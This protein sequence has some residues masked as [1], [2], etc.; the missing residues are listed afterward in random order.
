V[1][2]IAIYAKLETFFPPHHSRHNLLVNRLLGMQEFQLPYMYTLAA[3]A[4]IK[5]IL[6]MPKFSPKKTFLT[7][8]FLKEK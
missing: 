4:Q 3:L 5:S 1:A 8:N 2:T 7:Q 6:E